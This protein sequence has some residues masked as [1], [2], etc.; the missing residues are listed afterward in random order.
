MKKVN[1]FS[2]E[3]KWAELSMPLKDNL[4]EHLQLCSVCNPAFSHPTSVI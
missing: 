1:C 2:K 3:K 4:G